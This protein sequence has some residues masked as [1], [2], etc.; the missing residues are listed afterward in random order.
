MNGREDTLYK[1]SGSV[2]TEFCIDYAIMQGQ[3]VVLERLPCNTY[4]DQFEMTFPYPVKPNEYYDCLYIIHPTT[5][6]NRVECLG[7]GHQRYFFHRSPNADRDWIYALTI[8]LPHGAQLIAVDNE[9]TEVKSHDAV[10]VLR[11]NRLLHKMTEPSPGKSRRVQF[12]CTIEY[13]LPGESME[14]QL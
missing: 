8:R 3:E 7:N 1:T 14:T 10:T 11:W 2:D 6:K 5:E 12:E 9:P 13:Q 4:Q